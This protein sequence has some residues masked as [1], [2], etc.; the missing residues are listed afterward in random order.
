MFIVPQ[1]QA[2]SLTLVCGSHICVGID[3]EVTF[4][5]A[6][7]LVLRREQSGEHLQ[8]LRA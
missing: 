5:P 6:H 2:S 4:A 8:P 3:S 1:L 7:I